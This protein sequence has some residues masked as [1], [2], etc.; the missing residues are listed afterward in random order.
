MAQTT[1]AEITRAWFERVWNQGDE[2]AIDELFAPTGIAHGLP[3]QGDGKI[4]GPEAFKQFARVFKSAFPDLKIFITKSLVEADHCAVHCDVVG[5]H[6][7]DGL[8]IPATGRPVRFSGIS[9]VRV[10]NGQ[11]QEAWNCFDFLGL[12]QQLGVV[13]KPMT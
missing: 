1:P 11:I 12:F 8:G 9:I 7:G 3:V 6:K 4:K 2:A 13:S 10:D 5:N